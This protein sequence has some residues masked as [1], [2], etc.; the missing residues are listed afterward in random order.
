[1]IRVLSRSIDIAVAAYLALLRGLVLVIVAIV[2]VAVVFRYAFNAPLIFSFDLAVILFVWLIFLGLARAAHEG[3]HLSVDML[4]AMLPA[5]GARLADIAVRL[6][7]IAIAL[8]IAFHAFDL[9]T[10]TRLEI[11]TMRISMAWLYAAAPVG[12]ALFAGY[13]AYALIRVMIGRP[14]PRGSGGML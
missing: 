6:L 11:A 13:E 4:T 2:A 12:F 3:A 7:L 8:L 1:M 9:T 14:L 10:R 5:A